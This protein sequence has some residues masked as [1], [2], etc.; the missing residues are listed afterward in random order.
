MKDK[1]LVIPGK[2]VPNNGAITLMTYRRLKHLDLQMDVFTMKISKDETIE[3]LLKKDRYYKNFNI[4]YYGEYDNTIVIKK[5]Y[6][7]LTGLINM[8]RYV[9]ASVRKFKKDNYKYLYTS[10]LPGISHICG[11]KIKQISP[12]VMWYA[13]FSDPIKNAPY[14]NDPFI[15]KRGLLYRLMFKVGSFIYMNTKYEEAAIK[16]ADKLIFICEEQRDFTASQ[17]PKYKDLIIDKSMI[18]GLHYDDDWGS[19]KS[20]FKTNTP[21][22]ATH[23]G[24]I[25]GLRK[26]DKFLLAIKEMK[27]INNQLSEKIIFHQYGEIQP[28][29]IKFIDEQGLNDLFIVHDAIPY[30][31]VSG[32]L[33][34]SDILVIFD[35]IIEGGIQ[36]YLPSKIAEYIA[37]EKPIFGICD[38]NSPTYRIL[39]N[40]NHITSNYDKEMIKISINKLLT[41]EKNS[42]KKYECSYELNL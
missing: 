8:H 22:V 30:S 7:L 3:E 24:R 17:Y 16:Y 41:K 13:S 19:I 39:N 14:N 34:K 9:K 33:K 11:K 25:Y 29:Y 21:L 12:N 37:T 42:F 18:L 1:M 35:T 23:V 26:I 4:E 10:S 6:L 15:K 32:V 5:P 28:E 38:D 2:F 31:E 36:P 40:L 27:E 20:D